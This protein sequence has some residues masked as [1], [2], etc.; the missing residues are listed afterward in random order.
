MPLQEKSVRLWWPRMNWLPL[1]F[2]PYCPDHD[3]NFHQFLLLSECHSHYSGVISIQIAS[4]WINLP[5]RY[6][7]GKS[8]LLSGIF[9]CLLS[10]FINS[11][12]F[13]SVLDSCPLYIDLAI[14]LPFF[15][16]FYSLLVIHYHFICC[17]QHLNTCKLTLTEGK[18]SAC[19]AGDADSIPGLGGYPGGG[20]GNLFHILFWHFEGIVI[21]YMV[22]CYFITVYLIMFLWR[23]HVFFLPDFGTSF[24]FGVLLLFYYLL[25]YMLIQVHWVF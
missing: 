24:S 11:L 13:L 14:L 9:M 7:L 5:W 21:L 4:S 10:C 17:P 20:N 6:H 12:S 1:T 23:Y 3:F 22:F 2:Q 25:L 8:S 16:H 19:N 15:F 18:V